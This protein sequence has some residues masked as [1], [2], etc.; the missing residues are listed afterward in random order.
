[1]IS[2]NATRSS[3]ASVSSTTR[4]A[5]PNGIADLGLLRPVAPARPNHPASLAAHPDDP[6][7][8]W[9][10]A[11]HP[12]PYQTRQ[13]AARGVLVDEEQRTMREAIAVAELASELLAV[14]IGAPMHNFG[15]PVARKTWLD[16]LMTHPRFD[17]RLV[18][19]ALGDDVTF[20]IK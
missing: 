19:D 11:N 17:P 6:A 4:C 12:I 18:G 5:R 7:H 20:K 8:H 10:L 2:P 1:V 9:D 3:D 13:L 14:A 16:L 15:V